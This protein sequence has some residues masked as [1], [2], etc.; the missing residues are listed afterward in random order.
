MTCQDSGYDKD[1]LV[2]PSEVLPSRGHNTD[3]STMQARILLDSSTD[4]AAIMCSSSAKEDAGTSSSSHRKD[5][6]SHPS[7]GFITLPIP[8]GATMPYHYTAILQPLYYTQ[9]PPMHSDSGVI[10]KSAFQHASGQSNYHE[11]TSKTSQVDEQEQLEDHRLHH[12]RQIVRE[13]EEPVDLVRAHVEHVNQ[14]ASFSQDVRK[15]SGCTGSAEN[16]INTNTV[17][18]LE[19]GNESGVQNCGYNYNGLDSDRARRE[20]AL[21]KFRMKRK[22]RCFEKKVC[23][24]DHRKYRVTSIKTVV[25]ASSLFLLY[26]PSIYFIFHW[27]RLDII[28]GRSLQSKD[29]ESRGSL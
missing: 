21:I 23:L 12:S 11:N 16:D 14:S 19:S 20:A 18:A 10:N 7:Y 4:G 5:S 2:Q 6:L 8:V 9:A 22:D 25:I 28:P 3:E 27:Y 29:Q 17:V 26:L 1:L 13:S 24:L 15:G